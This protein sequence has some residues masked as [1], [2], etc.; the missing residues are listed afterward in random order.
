MSQLGPN[1]D[2][3]LPCPFCGGEA[4]VCQGGINGKFMTYGLV[5]HR[6]GCFFMADGLPTKNQHIMQKDFAAWNRRAE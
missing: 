6:E 1:S 2:Q 3:L 5:E 4:I